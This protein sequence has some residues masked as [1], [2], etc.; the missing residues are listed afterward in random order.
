MKH[1][2]ILGG[3]FGGLECYKRLTDFCRDD[4]RITL[5][6]RNN[7]SLFTPMLH[8][9]ATGSVSRSHIVQPLRE[10]ISCCHN[11]FI[12]QEISS[13]DIEKKVVHTTSLQIA[14][15]YLVVALGSSA[16][17]FGVKGAK[18]HSFALKTMHDAVGL[19]NHI[20]HQYEQAA[21]SIDTHERD[22]RLSFVIVGGGLTGVEMAGQLADFIIDMRELYPE[23]KKRIPEIVLVHAG[24]RLLPTLS[25]RSSRIARHI[26]EN[27]K[28]VCVVNK[29][30]QQVYQ[31]HVV[32][33]DGVEIKTRT[34]I[35][36]SGVQSSLSSIFPKSVLNERGLLN[37][38]NDLK[39]VHSKHIF[40]VGD[41]ISCNREFHPPMTA[42]SATQAG[43][44]VAENILATIDG[45]DTARF[46]FKSRGELVP[47][48]EW[49]GVAEIGWLKFHGKTAWWLRRTVFLQRLWSFTNRL[50]VVSDW[51]L[52][53]FRPRDTSEL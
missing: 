9:V 19:R 7:Y 13:V 27:K 2:V 25:S 6:N 53:I 8:E 26:L 20:L 28:V 51:T 31:D 14:Y 11:R 30:V 47:I 15:D 4:I 44:L 12:E 41:V 52:N 33:S 3:G 38:E 39:M 1:I 46:E 45:R 36:A 48:G 29:Q 34:T 17:F 10:V 18:E 49:N 22:E 35:W 40:G 16:N 32:L 23:I 43:R 37:V 5:I 42:Q 50:K 24:E 21:V